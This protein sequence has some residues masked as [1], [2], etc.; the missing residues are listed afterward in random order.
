VQ[1]LRKALQQLT[2]QQ[3]IERLVEQLRTTR[4]ND[5][6]LMNLVRKGNAIVR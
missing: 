4:T 3:A 6:F 1:G 5:E 2:P